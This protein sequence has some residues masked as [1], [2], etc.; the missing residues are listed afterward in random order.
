MAILHQAQHCLRRNTRCYS[1]LI[2][3]LFTLSFCAPA[4]AQLTPPPG[5]TAKLLSLDAVGSKVYSVA[6]VTQVSG[7]SLGATVN[8]DAIQAAANRLAHSGLFS[9][10]HYRYAT[11]VGGLRVTFELQDAPS[12]PISFDNFPWFTDDELFNALQQA[13][14][15]LRDTAPASGPFPDD[16]SQ[17][18]EKT[19]AIRNIQATV[20]HN[21][22]TDPVSE[23]KILEFRAVGA[24]LKIGSVQFSDPLAAGDATIR[25]QL[26]ILIGKPFSRLLVK[27][28]LAAHV[29]PIFLSH[30]FLH[31]HFGRPTAGFAGNPQGPL[32]KEVVVVAPIEPGPA[33]TWNGVSW[34]GSHMFSV[35]DLDTLVKTEGLSTGEPADGLKITALWDGLRS[36]YKHRGYLD[37]AVE[38]AE[39]FNEAAHQ[40]A[41]RVTISEGIQYRMGNLV[42]SGLNPESEQ[43]VHQAWQ[44]PQGQVFDQSFFDDFLS[45]RIAEALK[46][47][48]A[49]RDKIGNFLQK[50]PDKATVDVLL[51]FE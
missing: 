20:A 29:R 41:Y 38:T 25:T 12:F 22:V 32:P 13:G 17:T 30:S 46:G 49:S 2:V 34:S 28:F 44:I 51:D 19:L 42:L 48:P 43:R 5:Y 10:V 26:A 15:P 45:R 27:Q 1:L 18:L 23:S 24:N 11:D 40:A 14:I 50:N 21:L 47:L 31:V 4:S 8:L 37:I 33:Y 7:L 9:A 3:L 35:G 16:I 36:A 6:Q 39:N